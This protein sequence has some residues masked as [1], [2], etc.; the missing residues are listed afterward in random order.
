MRSLTRFSRAG[1]VLLAA[2]ITAAPAAAQFGWHITNPTPTPYSLNDVAAGSGEFLAVGANGTILASADGENWTQREAGTREAFLSVDHFA[3]TWY[4][5]G[6]SGAVF[7]SADG[8]NWEQR[9]NLDGAGEVAYGNGVVVALPLTGNYVRRSTEA[10][11]WANILFGDDPLNPVHPVSVAFAHGKFWATATPGGVFTSEDGTAWTRLDNVPATYRLARLTAGNGHLLA[12]AASP[13]YLANT[14]YFEIDADGNWTALTSPDGPVSLQFVHDRF[15][16]RASYSQYTSPDGQ[17]WTVQPH[18]PS[19][20]DGRTLAQGN[21]RWLAIDR[22]H[23]L[24]RTDDLGEWTAVHREYPVA[25]RGLAHLDGWFLNSTG[26]RSADGV[27]WESGG[28][29]PSFAAGS[30]DYQLTQVN[31]RTFATLQYFVSNLGWQFE[32]WRVDSDGDGE[33]LYQTIARRTNGQIHY[34]NGLY[35]TFAVDPN[36]NPI[37]VTSPDGVTW[38]AQPK[39][40]E[41]PRPN[42]LNGSDGERFWG[43]SVAGE[44]FTSTDGA[45]WTHVFTSA[46]GMVPEAVAV[47]SDWVFFGTARTDANSR[48]GYYYRDATGT[49][50]YHPS[51]RFM[52]AFADGD[53]LHAVANAF[54]GEHIATLSADHTWSHL[55]IPASW[56]YALT[57]LATSDDRAVLTVG[58][59]VAVSTTDSDLA[60]VRALP[61]DSDVVLGTPTDLTVEVLS[62]SD[63]D[64]TYQ[65]S[66]NGVDILGA[67]HSSLTVTQN[68]VPANA[69]SLA[70]RISDGATTLQTATSVHF[71]DSA[72]P[73]FTNSAETVSTNYTSSGNGNFTLRL[74]TS[75]SGPGAI[76]YQW[77]RND[78]LLQS[79]PDSLLAR[80]LT[81]ADIGDTFT[82]VVSNTLGSVTSAPFVLAGP[83]P[84]A[85]G[86][87]IG[88]T[89]VLSPD[90]FLA[91]SI[92]QPQHVDSIQ[93][94]R[95]GIPVPGATSPS[96]NRTHL[97]ATDAGY[98][99]VVL[100]N[101]WGSV[102]LGPVFVP[103]TGGWL[104]NVSVRAWSGEDDA[105]LIPGMV[106]A[107][108][109]SLSVPVFRAVGPSL[110]EHGVTNPL[111][112]PALRILAA[113]GIV[114]ADNDQWHD[115]STNLADTFAAVGAFPLPVDSLDAAAIP[116]TL[117]FTGQLLRLTAPIRSV[118]IATGEVLAEIYRYPS[119]SDSNPWPHRLINLSCRAQTGPGKPMIA[120]FV[121]DGNGPVRLL[122]RAAGPALTPKGV[123]G[124]LAN[125]RLIL[126]NADGE[127]IGNNDTWT[128]ADNLADLRTAAGIVGAFEFSETGNDAAM[129]VTLEPGLYTAIVQSVD[130]TEGIAL[131]E[132]YE[133]P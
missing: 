73:Y 129:F 121:I 34:A 85:I 103:V 98:W 92:A 69:L 111:P 3:G 45:S 61:P 119:R 25:S 89:S 19:E 100:S 99:D 107:H 70:V 50:T 59:L 64:V 30:D 131:V 113:D 29:K 37:P 94:R 40:T 86:P 120:G 88:D 47:G 125:P 80:Q 2:L 27:T 76:T 90:G 101:A 32:I 18:F 9:S 65:W 83:L 130:A 35:A 71:F 5:Y 20:L 84:T 127:E 117:P 132:L 39:L 46:Y 118:G 68:E 123:T 38:T 55:E 96:L 95:N 16:L 48:V 10:G 87:T 42:Y 13:P 72:A 124:A 44:V 15:F 106:M 115:F 62:A 33:R 41:N 109:T 21:G 8:R 6:T 105:T 4:A 108:G 28:W 14:P 67:T 74:N 53:A 57:G 17:T 7:S 26:Q 36:G 63:R 91:L 126:F 31:G 122:I 112:D 102:T 23:H 78:E 52:S 81:A 128:E 11:N 93:W 60:F 116:A 75:V 58:N 77:F 22:N 82:V 12:I 1:T 43:V 79:G 110:T 114:L 56:Q 54:G 97:A 51:F 104:A 49:W 66:A 24:L 133:V